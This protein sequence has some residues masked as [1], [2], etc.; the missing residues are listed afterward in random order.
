MTYLID[1]CQKSQK[2]N[3]SEGGQLTYFTRKGTQISEKMVII[4]FMATREMHFKTTAR[5]LCTVI[6]K[7]R[8]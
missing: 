3:P 4:D 2:K 1:S 5:Y 7:L 8:F 6:L